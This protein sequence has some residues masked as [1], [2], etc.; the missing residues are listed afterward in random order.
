MIRVPM[1]SGPKCDC[2]KGGM[3]YV[4]LGR[5]ITEMGNVKEEDSGT[6]RSIW[7]F[8]LCACECLSKFQQI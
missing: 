4:C 5:D 2:H 6:S 3:G 8:S 1:E 7:D